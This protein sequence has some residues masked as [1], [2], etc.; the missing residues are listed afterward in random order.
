MRRRR[1]AADASTPEEREQANTIQT[2]AALGALALLLL[3][4]QRRLWAP[5]K[6]DLIARLGAQAITPA[7]YNRIV[8][9]WL[10]HWTARYQ[11]TAPQLREL[12]D[13]AIQRL[14]RVMGSQIDRQLINAG[15]PAVVPVELPSVARKLGQTTGSLVESTINGLTRQ[16]EVT[17]MAVRQA[18]LAE[19]PSQR[20]VKALEE[21]IMAKRQAQ[22]AAREAEATLVAITQAEAFKEAGVDRAVW[23]TRRD[24]RVRPSHRARDGRTYDVD[25][26]L[27]GVYPSQEYL[28]RCVGVPVP[29]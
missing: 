10:D 25:K 22:M 8:E 18:A 19:L 6:A 24:S 5:A 15:Y 21:S 2:D 13:P 26:G 28:C 16:A 20:L 29:R 9:T 27:D 7:Q 11:T 23:V 4:A 12:I 1:F 17:T 3:R 14:G